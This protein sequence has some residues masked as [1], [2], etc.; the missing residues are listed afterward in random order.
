MGY[1]VDACACDT[2]DMR[3]DIQIKEGHAAIFTYE[4]GD[5]AQIAC[6]CGGWES[7]WSTS[8]AVLREYVEHLEG[9]RRKIGVRFPIPEEGWHSLS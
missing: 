3:I 7:S 2:K 1:G 6:E 9:G 8:L 4:S 5:V